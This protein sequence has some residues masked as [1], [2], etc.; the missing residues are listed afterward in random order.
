MPLSSRFCHML[1]KSSTTQ[2][3]PV[4]RRD[5]ACFV[6][7]ALG[8]CLIIS[9]G[10]WPDTAHVLFG[11]QGICHPIPSEES[12]VNSSWNSVPINDT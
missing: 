1:V 10:H 12:P 5:A 4:M 8:F 2:L 6:I 11:Q 7:A 9:M 3:E